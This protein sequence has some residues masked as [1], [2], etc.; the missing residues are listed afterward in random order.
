[1]TVATVGV[2][3]DSDGYVLRGGNIE[4][5]IASVPSVTVYRTL[6]PG[7]Y[8]IRLEGIAANCA[9][10]GP[11]LLPVTIVEGNL[12]SVSFRV[13]C[14]A[15]TGAFRVSAPTTGRDFANASY[16]VVV[17]GSGAVARSLSVRPNRAADFESMP[18]GTYE[19]TLE[20]RADNC[21]VTGDDPQTAA[22]VVGGAF[23]HVT[24]VTFPVECSPT[25]GDVHLVA[26]TI[27]HD[28]DP[29]GYAVWRDGREL[30]LT[31]EDPFYYPPYTRSFPLRLAAD[32]DGA[33]PEVVPGT[34]GYELRDLA[35]N[36]RVDG[37]NPRTVSVAAGI[38]SEVR[39]SVS[40]ATLP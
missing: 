34:H 33:D 11:D 26:T 30:I 19:L 28:P 10:D 25:T 31:Y 8:E 40:C 22:I 7:S 37:A 12:T 17:A 16:L 38:T 3:L 6:A 13:Q 35:A 39:F 27:G 1:V 36:C 2:D 24:E 29:D 15:T 9:F 32:G 4:Q 5:A 21:K 14:A 23:H 18:G 20:T